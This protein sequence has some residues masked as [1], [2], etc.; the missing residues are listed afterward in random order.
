MTINYNNTIPFATM[1]RLAFVASAF[2][3]SM[4]DQKIISSD[5]YYSIFSTV[6]SPM[7]EFQKDLQILSKKHTFN[8]NNTQLLSSSLF[9]IIV[10]NPAVL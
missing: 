6:N 8:N 2:L 4:L 1:A 9:K 5:Q 7:I 10:N 3:K